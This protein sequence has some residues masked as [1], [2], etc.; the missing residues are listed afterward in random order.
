MST[1]AIFLTAYRVACLRLKI[2]DVDNDANNDNN[3]EDLIPLVYQGFMTIFHFQSIQILL[4]GHDQIFR[5][6][7]Y[8]DILDGYDM[9]QQQEQDVILE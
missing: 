4:Y 2:I 5:I 1:R 3:K 7:T 6:R 8:L 9:I